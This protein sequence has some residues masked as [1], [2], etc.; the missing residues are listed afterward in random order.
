MK[1]RDCMDSPSLQPPP[2]RESIPT[3]LLLQPEYFEQLFSLM[4]TL[5]A[6]KT[7]TKGGVSVSCLKMLISSFEEMIFQHH[8]PHTKAQVLSRRVWDILSLL[9]TNPTL[10]QGFKQLN[11]PL[12][13]L[14]DPSSPQKL[15]YSL[16]IVESLSVKTSKGADGNSEPWNRVFIQQGGLRHLYDIFM[17]GKERQEQIV[18]NLLTTDQ[19]VNHYYFQAS[20]RDRRATAANGNRTASPPF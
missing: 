17:S 7:P 13:E 9:P 8:I 1:R 15:M 6:M 14:L 2:P 4:H 18:I 19:S 5:S 10:L 3:L 16:Y 20:S 11:T 12:A